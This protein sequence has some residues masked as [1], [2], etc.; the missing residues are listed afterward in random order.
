LDT[1]T[2]T[3]ARQLEL[4]MDEWQPGRYAVDVD[5]AW[6]CPVIPHGGVMASIASRAMTL[7]LARVAAGDGP[8]DRDGAESM[9]LRTQTTVF[10]APVPA[11]PVTIDVDVLRSGRTMSQARAEVRAEGADPGVGHTTV[12][13]F[14]RPRRGFELVDLEMPEVPPPDDCPSFRDEPPEG[15]DWDPKAFPFWLHVEGRPALGHAPWDRWEPTTSDTA[16]WMR[17]DV[18][19]TRLDGSLDPL[20]LVTFADT[21]PSAVGELLGPDDMD[22]YAPSADLTVHVLAEPRSEWILA[23]KRL[24]RATD[25]YCSAEVALWDPDPAVGLVAHATQVMFFTVPQL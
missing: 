24:R 8:G 12:A 16:S 6:N 5:P 17:F 1:E 10:A 21:M 23:H 18:S 15:A 9:A 3:F 19:P 13:V 25:G 4:K 14:G 22:W 20:A 7:E 2:V 11:G